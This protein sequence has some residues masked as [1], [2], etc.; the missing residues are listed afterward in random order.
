MIF[1][2][3][4]SSSSSS[5]SSASWSRPQL[6]TSALLAP[7]TSSTSSTIQAKGFRGPGSFSN[8]DKDVDDFILMKGDGYPTYHFANVVDDTS[9][10]ITHVFRG[11]VSRVKILREKS[12]CL[13]TSRFRDSAPGMAAIHSQALSTLPSTRMDCASLCASSATRQPGRYQAEQA[14]WRRQRRKLSGKGVMEQVP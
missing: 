5:S 6:P 11:E 4:S 7:K 14:D 10:G 8:R 13:L 3:Y 9:M 1:G 12:A 2:A